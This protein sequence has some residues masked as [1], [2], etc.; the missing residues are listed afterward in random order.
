LFEEAVEAIGPH[1]E[2]DLL[3]LVAEHRIGCFERDAAGIPRR[4]DLHWSYAR[5]AAIL[6][7][8]E[9][10]K[11]LLI[12]RAALYQHFP[13]LPPTPR[14]GKRVPPADLRQWFERE[15]TGVCTQTAIERAARDKFGNKVTRGQIRALTAHLDLRPGRPKKINS[16]K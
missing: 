14:D 4:I 2:G 16:P 8:P 5:G 13:P 7:D 12:E 3:G 6:T 10:R 1:N 11:G 15:Y 9:A